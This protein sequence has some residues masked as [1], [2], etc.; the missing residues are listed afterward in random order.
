[1][2]LRP[3]LHALFGRG[4]RDQH[5][6]TVAK[7][8]GELQQHR[9]ARAVVGARC[10][11]VDVPD[12]VIEREEVVALLFNVSG[13]ARSLERIELL[14]GGDDGEEETDEG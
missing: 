6:G 12:P 14:L 9:D 13:V 5:A 7:R 3:R 1:M 4:R 8:G 10:N 11:P 2:P